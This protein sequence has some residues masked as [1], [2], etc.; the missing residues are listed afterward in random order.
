MKKF[1]F[2]FV[3]LLNTFF[4]Y[5][6]RISYEQIINKIQNQEYNRAYT[7]LFEYQQQKPEEPYVYFALGNISYHYLVNT[8]V[9]KNYDDFD[10]YFYNTKLFYGLCL[11]KLS[12]KPKDVNRN[13]EYYQIVNE[14]KIKNLETPMVERFLHERMNY[15]K[16]LEEI[17]QNALFS[18]RKFVVLYNNTI[19]FYNQIVQ[20]YPNLNDLYLVH[21]DTL[22]KLMSDVTMSFDSAIFYFELYK[23]Y[24]LSKYFPQVPDQKIKYRDIKFYILD[25]SQR[26]NLMA[27]DILIWNYKKWANEVM[28]YVN[29]NIFTLRKNIIDQYNKLK[30][31]EKN[32]EENKL[33]IFEKYSLEPTT[34]FM[35]EKYDNKS[36]ITE[37]LQYK[38]SYINLLLIIKKSFKNSSVNIDL[39]KIFFDFSRVIHQKNL[40]NYNL[41]NLKKTLSFKNYHKHEQFIDLYFKNYESFSNFVLQQDRIIDSLVQ[42]VS[43]NLYYALNSSLNPRVQNFTFSVN[44]KSYL[45]KDSYLHPSFVAENEGSVYFSFKEKNTKFYSGYLKQKNIVQPFYLVQTDTIV[46]QF[47]LLSNR[48]NEVAYYFKPLSDKNLLILRN[49]QNYESSLCLETGSKIQYCSSITR[50]N[51]VRRVLVDEINNF[52]YLIAFG[53]N[54][55]VNNFETDTMKIMKIDLSKGNKIWT[56]N[57]VFTGNVVNMFKVDTT[58]H[59]FVNAEKM[60]LPTNVSFQNKV[61]DVK[62]TDNGKIADFVD[63]STIL[64]SKAYCNYV[65]KI[66]NR[67]YIFFQKSEKLEQP[68]LIYDERT[69]V[70]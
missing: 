46:E 40:V 43:K 23:K 1:V 27:K 21:Y 30:Q 66:D 26:S 28:K 5:S 59:V 55:E 58:V 13:K 54:W 7:L 36:M 68:L 47:G 65:Q 11:D 49:L 35:I 16:T 33:P 32:L 62:I 25:G 39:D 20:K 4:I 57:I 69:V 41:Q 15:L 37:L 24:N 38:V 6:Q 67:T 60:Q 8:N 3:T 53:Q 51:L 63:Y 34:V 2:L 19:D 29:T 18:Y 31:L 12:K 48:N 10:Y 64:Q 9:L 22:S 61:I 14:L 44:K 50:N 42:M 52:V 45:L 56:Q 70:K 17:V